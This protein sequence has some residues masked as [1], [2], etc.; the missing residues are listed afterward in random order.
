MAGIV[1]I[2]WYA[3]GFRAE[4]LEAAL[5]DVTHTAQ[6]YG[7]TSWFVHRSRDDRYKFL[8]ALE[9]ES[10]TDFE[11]WWHGQEMTDFR[12]MCSNWYQIPLLYVWH[13]VVTQGAVEAGVSA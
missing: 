4:T 2:P 13:D 3:T 12:A 9:F 10:K 6:R 5:A 11:R 8:Q 7:A 1:H